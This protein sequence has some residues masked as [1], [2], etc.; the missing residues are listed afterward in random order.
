[1]SLGGALSMSGLLQGGGVYR[2]AGV[3]VTCGSI[4]V[5]VDTSQHC[6]GGLQSLCFGFGG[7]RHFLPCLGRH[8]G[9]RAAVFFP[10]HP[11]TAPLTSHSVLS[12]CGSYF[13]A[14]DPHFVAPLTQQS[15][16]SE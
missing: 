3:W 6:L 16:P 13:P 8:L 12:S 9:E 15:P 10:S 4:L 5:A 14:L 2:T 11:S 7:G 1:M